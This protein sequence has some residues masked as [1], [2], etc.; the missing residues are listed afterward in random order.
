VLQQTLARADQLGLAPVLL[1]QQNDL[2]TIV[3]LQ[4]WR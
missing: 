3:D 1:P 4:A 2:D